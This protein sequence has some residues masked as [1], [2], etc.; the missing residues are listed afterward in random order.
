MK[1]ERSFKIPYSK[2]DMNDNYA[3][4]KECLSISQHVKG[5]KLNRIIKR[6]K[7]YDYF[8]IN[9]YLFSYWK[10]VDKRSYR[11]LMEA[12]GGVGSELYKFDYTEESLNSVTRNVQKELLKLFK[13][14][15]EY[16]H[17]YLKGLQYL[18]Q[19]LVGKYYYSGHA[20]D[21]DTEP[22]CD[23]LEEVAKAIE[24]GNVEKVAKL[25]AHNYLDWWD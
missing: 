16:D 9:R 13:H 25:Y 22:I 14:M 18:L 2:Q 15:Q 3:K 12:M 1:N 24:K 17:V 11:H 20:V 10:Q 5:K 19:Y 4:F 6:Y 21:E 7:W 23:G 8:Y